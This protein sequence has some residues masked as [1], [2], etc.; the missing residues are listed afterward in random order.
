MKLLTAIVT[1][2]IVLV[3]SAA[4]AFPVNKQTVLRTYCSYP[5]LMSNP[6][7]E[8]RCVRFALEATDRGYSISVIKKIADRIT[9]EH[10][11]IGV[12][13]VSPITD[14]NIRGFIRRSW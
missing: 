6:T 13:S 10:L 12:E 1:A 3:P 8:R 2:A 7:G 14:S 11:G 5:G 4:N 9:A